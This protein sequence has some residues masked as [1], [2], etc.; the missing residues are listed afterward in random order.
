MASISSIRLKCEPVRSLAFGLIVAGYTGVSTA[1]LK[2]A[3]IIL[4]Q[5]LTDA[6]LMFSFDAVD[7]HFPLPAQGQFVLDITAN[8]SLTQGFYLAEGQR[9]YVKRIG[10]PASGSVYLTVFYGAE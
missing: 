1:L 3:R 4:V 5:N 8:K 2:P 7:D 10:T 9:L 6:A